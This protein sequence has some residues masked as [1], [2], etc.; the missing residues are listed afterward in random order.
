MSRPLPPAERVRAQVRE[1]AGPI[2]ADAL[3]R[4]YQ[5][6]GS[7]LVVRLP[8]ELRPHFPTIGAAWRSELAVETV[9][10]HA[11][12]T[13]GEDRRP[14]VEII[15]GRNS[16]ATVRENG[17]SYR[18]D[19]A[20]VM[21][22]AGNRTERKRAG[23]VTRPGETVV[24]LFAG[25]GY[26][27]LPAAVHGRAA[28]VVAVERNPTAFEYLCE[29]ARLNQ[30]AE[31]IRPVLGDNRV[32]D[33]PPGHAD[34]IFLGYLPSSLPWIGRSLQLIRPGGTIHV[35]LVGSTREGI[36][37]VRATVRRTV[38][39]GGGRPLSLEA[40]EV[41]PYGPGTAHYVVDVIVDTAAA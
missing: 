34:R 29:N 21:F 28:E 4:G 30:V 11:G 12:M 16:V 25:I 23:E 8:E 19:A 13:D 27:A 32:I 10:R 41:K 36:D 24:D 2:V 7:V 26:F 35:H 1:L 14:R 17:I 33:L 38:E 15:A 39:Q 20:R 18:L 3:P 9:L 40:R 22:A 37:G 6:L 31:R 5:R